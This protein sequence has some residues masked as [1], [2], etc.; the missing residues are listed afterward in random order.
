MITNN[1]GF[2]VSSIIYSMLVL[3]L[4]LV[5]LIMSN[6]AS[7]KV[8]FDKQKNDI[9]D[10][11][12]VKISKD[13]DKEAY[14]LYG[15]THES[16]SFEYGTDI[17]RIAA[18]RVPAGFYNAYDDFSY[19]PSSFYEKFIYSS[20]NEDEFFSEY[21]EYLTEIAEYIFNNYNPIAWGESGFFLEGWTTSAAGSNGIR[22]YKD[23]SE[24]IQIE[25][26]CNC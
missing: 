2:A 11:F 10:K 19:Y 15:L 24:I 3:F 9:L 17:F 4:S 16:K 21:K 26:T 7:R 8:I 25:I 23:D 12:D 13:I 1:R 20:D 5:L 14:E 6:L 18:D 22:F